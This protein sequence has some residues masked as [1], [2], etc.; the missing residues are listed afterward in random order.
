MLD[1]IL[2]SVC[3]CRLAT[4]VLEQRM[5]SCTRVTDIQGTTQLT[6]W[7]AHDSHHV[8]SNMKETCDVI[9]G[10]LQSNATSAVSTGVSGRSISHLMLFRQ[11][12]HVPAPVHISGAEKLS[13]EPTRHRFYFHCR[14]KTSDEIA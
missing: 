1:F 8:Y 5:I 11:A 13:L 2:L 4:V 7:S 3:P 12:M 6:R 10:P 9:T 14:S